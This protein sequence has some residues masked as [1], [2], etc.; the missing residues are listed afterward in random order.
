MP[1]VIYGKNGQVG[2]ALAEQLGAGAVVFASGDYDFSDISIIRAALDGLNAKAVI[3]AAAYTDVNKAETEE[4]KAYKANAMIPAALAKYCLEKN[5]PFI[6]Y[7]TDYVFPG[8]GNLPQKENAKT[9]PLNAYGRSK[10][11]GEEKIKEIGGKYLILRTSWVYDSCRKNF[12]TTMLKLASERETLSVVDD[13]YGAPTYAPHLAKATVEILRKIGCGPSP[14]PNPLPGGEGSIGGLPGREEGDNL[15]PSGI[16][17]L[18]GGGEVSWYGFATQ[19]FKVAKGMGMP[20]KIQAVT[21]ISAAEFSTTVIRPQNSRLDCTRVF[22]TFGVKM[23]HW[24]ESLKEALTCIV[25]EA[26]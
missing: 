25:R 2:A 13:Q 19:I 22:E 14:H 7:S 26:I 24:E 5:I 6:H 21:P 11:A 15:F 16:Y 23:P 20:L 12:L 3:N 1:I 8:E 10:Q 9:S 18:C 17:H 4:N